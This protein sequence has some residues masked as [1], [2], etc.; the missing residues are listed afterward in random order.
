MPAMRG[1]RIA[2]DSHPVPAALSEVHPPLVIVVTPASQLDLVD[3]RLAAESIRVQ[4][5]ELD[6][7]APVAAMAGRCDEGATTE[8]PD[9]D[10]ALH[11][12]RDVARPR[13]V[14]ARRARLRR[15]ST[16]A[17]NR[18]PHGGTRRESR[19]RRGV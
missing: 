14:R 8:I 4:V 18:N 16:R 2:H 1:R 10:R 9:P 15:S 19:A 12:G 3:T 17:G 6:E 5:M 7:P 13:I 11:R